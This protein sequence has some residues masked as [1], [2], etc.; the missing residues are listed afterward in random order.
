MKRYTLATALYALSYSTFSA[1]A[2]V[3]R[4]STTDVCWQVGVPNSTALSSNGNIYFQLRAP[5]TYSWVALGTG[6]QM[7]GSNLFV[8]YANGAGNVTVSPRRAS[9][10]VEPEHQT[11]THIELLA[12]SGIVDGGNTMLAN[13]RCS[14]CE[15]WDGGSLTV[16]SSKSPFVAAWKKGSA[17]NSKRLDAGISRHDSHDQFTFNLARAVVSADR[18]PF[19]TSPGGGTTSPPPPGGNPDS[20]DSGSIGLPASI[21]EIP[22][23]R[24]AHG[25][26]MS[27]V[28]VVLYPLGS[29]LMPLFGNWKMHAAWQL[30][31]FLLM[32]AAFGIGVVLAQRTGYNFHTSH[33]LLGT[34]V[35]A[36]FGLQPIG[37]YLHHLYYLKHRSRGAISYA[38]IWYGRILMLEGIVN[39]GLGLKLAGAGRALV[40]AY[41]VIAAI[42]S[43]AYVLSSLKGEMKRRRGNTPK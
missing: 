30:T 29:I 32:W 37:G 40:I 34:V 42:I 24:S 17:I 35:V 3:S 18:N 27:I 21:R 39:G 6:T 33:T 10:Y 12:G 36:L 5:A 11:D 8:M 15:S 25:I 43:S 4:C 19:V 31:S 9:G 2:T 13:V 26:L 28:M 38:H 20:G 41:S 16:S 7:A 22:T 1:G 14:N 23:L